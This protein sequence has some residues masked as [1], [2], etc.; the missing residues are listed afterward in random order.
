MFEIVYNEKPETVDS[1]DR[2]QSLWNVCVW[3]WWWCVG[4]GGGERGR[5]GAVGYEKV[6]RRIVSVA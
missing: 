2:T 6:A 4:G 1:V 5:G 3:W